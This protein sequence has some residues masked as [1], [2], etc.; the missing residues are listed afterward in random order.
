MV[1]VQDRAGLTPQAMD[2]FKKDLL[3]VITKY[4]VLE[5]E[6][7]EVNWERD[8]NSTALII[9]TPVIGRSMKAKAVAAS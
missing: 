5:R 2:L 4:F 8:T 7:L 6:Q 1:L 3:E 9:N